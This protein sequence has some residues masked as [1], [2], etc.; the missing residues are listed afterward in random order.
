MWP[1]P[2]PSVSTK[3]E[4][5]DPDAPCY[6]MKSGG[7]PLAAIAAAG[8]QPK[9]EPVTLDY[10]KSEAVSASAS[11]G[12]EDRFIK[13]ELVGDAQHVLPPPPPAAF[14]ST[15]CSGC[16]YSIHE[17]FILKV[18][19]K[20]WHSQCLRQGATFTIVMSVYNS[21]SAGVLKGLSHE[22]KFCFKWYFII[23]R[24]FLALKNCT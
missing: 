14:G 7:V 1:A 17:E 5:P 11:V 9:V 3:T 8:R 16:G 19:E 21:E 4:K 18:G 6:N 20:S 24:C 13:P 22:V 15:A 12:D 10:I 2:V 23:L